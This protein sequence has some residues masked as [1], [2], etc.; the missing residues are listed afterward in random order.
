MIDLDDLITEASASGGSE[1]ANYQ[2]F[3][4]RLGAVL[5]VP[6]PGMSR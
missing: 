4:T 2:L 3:I 5:G 6:E 1:R